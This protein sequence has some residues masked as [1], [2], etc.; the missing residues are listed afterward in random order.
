[1]GRTNPKN[2][3]GIRTSLAS[4]VAP[5]NAPA[6]GAAQAAQIAL[7]SK[8]GEEMREPRTLPWVSY[9]QRR[10]EYCRRLALMQR[11][12][13]IAQELHEMARRYEDDADTAP[14]RVAAR[15]HAK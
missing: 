13:V 9:P 10:A 15:I 1:M 14:P 8:D 7:L 6:N 11:D 5:D 12:P 4:S 2:D 3:T